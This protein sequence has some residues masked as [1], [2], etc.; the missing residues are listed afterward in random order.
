MAA[1]RERDIN[2]TIVVGD[3]EHDMIASNI[4]RA[5]ELKEEWDKKD[6]KADKAATQEPAKKRVGRPR[7]DGHTFTPHERYTRAK[8]DDETYIN[9]KLS[10]EAHTRLRV[11]VVETGAKSAGEYLTK[12]IMNDRTE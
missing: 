6:N 9:V 10:R 3:E 2:G 8:N 7:K 5:R 12:L 11:R 1:P 4:K